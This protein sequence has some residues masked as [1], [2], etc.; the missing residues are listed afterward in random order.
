MPLLGIFSD[1][2][3]VCSRPLSR[4]HWQLWF[5]LSPSGTAARGSRGH[6]H[7]REQ[8]PQARAQPGEQARRAQHSTADGARPGLSGTREGRTRS[9]QVA[10]QITR[11]PGSC[12]GTCG[13]SLL[14]LQR[15]AAVK[16][17]HNSA[18]EDRVDRSTAGC[19][20]PEGGWVLS[21]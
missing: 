10:P 12:V 5:L 1:L 21:V 13:Q 16:L 17:L 6:R 18:L 8:T 14:C 20:V 9:P 2:R 19:S 4:A 15:P 3:L 11:A 7:P